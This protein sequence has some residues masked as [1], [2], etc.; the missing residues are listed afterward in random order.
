MYRY[1]R[2]LVGLTLSERDETIIRY[3]AMV[4]RMAASKKVYFVHVDNR[5]E[6]PEEILNAY[7]EAFSDEDEA[8]ED[9]MAEMV[10]QHFD[11][12]PDTQLVYDVLDGSPITEIL[13]TVCRDKID[14]VLVG[15]TAAHQNSGL[16][17]EKLARKA[18][19]S[20]LVIPE[21]TEARISHLLVAT[22]FSDDSTDA[23]EAAIAF[24]RAVPLSSMACL[25]AYWFPKVMHP[26]TDCTDQEFH[27]VL[28]RCAERRYQDFIRSFDLDG[29]SVI[30]LLQMEKRAANAVT[31]AVQTQQADFVVLGAR[32]RTAA[33][34]VLLGSVTERLISSTS[35]PLLAVKKKGT[36]LGFLEALLLKA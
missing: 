9:R 13:D 35:V 17:P 29:L 1:R 19:C 28:R 20:V 23:M 4:S 11:G 14:L 8:I 12:H 5:P 33:A 7:P 16:L 10:R 34:A 24:A 6:V 25:H 15:R 36:G 32:G 27:A 2:I 18:P 22:D 31:R 21:G 3:A 30:P 26:A